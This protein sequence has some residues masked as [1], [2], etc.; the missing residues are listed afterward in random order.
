M[1]NTAKNG[2]IANEDQTTN[3]TAGEATDAI[4]TEETTDATVQEE[5]TYPRTT[6]TETDEYY[7]SEKQDSAEAAVT[8]KKTWKDGS[9]VITLDQSGYEITKYAKDG[10]V[11]FVTPKTKRKVEIFVGSA[12]DVLKARRMVGNKMDEEAFTQASIAQLTKFDG[13]F[14]P[15]E[16][17]AKKGFLGFYEYITIMGVFQDINF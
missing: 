5:V 12:G 9:K 6:E 15:P 11:E 17:I 1:T 3:S 4:A 8:W 13:Q 16:A 2:E 10:H 7:M 14:M